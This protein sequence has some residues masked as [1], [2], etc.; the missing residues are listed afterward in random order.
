[1]AKS[2]VAALYTLTT[3]WIWHD[4][5]TIAHCAKQLRATGEPMS[6]DHSSSNANDDTVRCF[7][8][9]KRTVR[10]LDTA[11][12]RSAISSIWPGLSDRLWSMGG[13]VMWKITF[14]TVFRAN[15]LVRFWCQF[16]PETWTQWK[17]LYLPEAWWF[18]GGWKWVTLTH[19]VILLSNG[20]HRSEI[21]YK[22]FWTRNDA[23]TR[24]RCVCAHKGI[25]NG[26]IRRFVCFD[27]ENVKQKKKNF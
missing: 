21:S 16:P 12:I 18:I 10:Q 20:I 26:A 22:R 4:E 6:I 7:G 13:S 23:N 11:G 3:A 8:M 17:V 25:D 2:T 9:N 14:E 27:W 5:C 1:M 15:G 19:C 24:P